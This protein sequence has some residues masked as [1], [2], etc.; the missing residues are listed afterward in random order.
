VKGYQ[1]SKGTGTWWLLWS[2]GDQTTKLQ[3]PITPSGVYDVYGNPGQIGRE[4][5]V[6][7]SPV[8]ID[9]MP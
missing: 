8:Y 4:I 2:V 5:V 6:G 7:K 3:L 9:F 1:F